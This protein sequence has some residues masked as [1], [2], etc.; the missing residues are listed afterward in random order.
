MLRRRTCGAEKLD[1]LILEVPELSKTSEKCT[2]MYVGPSEPYRVPDLRIE[3]WKNEVVNLGLV[4]G[5]F[6]TMSN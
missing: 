1:I 3:S 6:H 5:D 2:S 4:L